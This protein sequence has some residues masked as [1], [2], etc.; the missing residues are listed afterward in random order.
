MKANEVDILIVPGYTNSDKDH[1]QSRWEAKLSTAKRVELGDWHKPVLRDW[2]DNL[3]AAVHSCRK[4]VLLVAHSLGVPTVIHAASQMSGGVCGAFLVAP[5]D[6]QNPDIRPKHLMS[7]G[8]YPRN[9]LPFPSIVIA[10]RNDSFCD[11]ATAES[12]AKS[13]HSLFLDAGESGHINTKSG[14]GPWPEGLMVFSQFLAKLPQPAAFAA[15]SSKK[16]E[17]KKKHMAA[18]KKP[19]V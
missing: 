18:D 10:A 14:H 17:A 16:T 6:T 13:W 19:E 8:P 9:P 4:P 5:P 2:V 12:L 3:I 11:F 7:F 15:A 1:W